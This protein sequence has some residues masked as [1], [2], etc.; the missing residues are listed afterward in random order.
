VDEAWIIRYIADTFAG[1]DVVQPEAGCGA[2]QNPLPRRALE[3]AANSGKQL[4]GSV[5]R[6]L[7]G[8]LQ[9][10]DGSLATSY[11]EIP[12]DFA[13]LPAKADLKRDTHL[14]NFYIASRAKHLLKII[15]TRGHLDPSYPYPVEAWPLDGL[16]WIF[17]GGEVVVDYSLRLK[18][19]LRG[20]HTWV[21]AYCNDV[22]PHIPSQRVLKEGRYEGGGAM[23]YYGQPTVWSDQVEE[24]ILGAVARRVG[25]LAP[26]QPGP[27]AGPSHVER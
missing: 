20:S 1:V 7:A 12:L 13:T 25:E 19:S 22:M 27:P 18:R 3:L 14:P 5:T 23:V 2:D 6:V 4:T 21:S 17:L 9:D 16:T 15:E 11:E 8:A 24:S 10:I 26:P